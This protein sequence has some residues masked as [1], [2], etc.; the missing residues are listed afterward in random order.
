MRIASRMRDSRA[1]ASSLRASARAN[2]RRW[3]PGIGKPSQIAFTLRSIEEPESGALRQVE[4]GGNLGQRH[5][6]APRAEQFEHIQ[7]LSRGFHEIRVKLAG[8]RG[9]R[10]SRPVSPEAAGKLEMSMDETTR[11]HLL[12]ETTPL[13][14]GDDWAAI[15][16]IWEPYVQTDDVDAQGQLA[17]LYQFYGFDEGPEKD[18]EM[19]AMLRTAA[20]N[21]HADA[22]FCLAI[23][24]PAGEE[25]DEL[26]RKAAAHGNR[27]AQCGLGALYATGDWTGPKDPPL[28]VYWYTRAA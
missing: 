18:R 27:E 4:R 21:G 7:H 10:I 16:R 3:A 1:A 9:E 20:A 22:E 15:E 5:F 14:K 24:S 19:Q 28:A 12:T 6:L 8:H 11:Q 23:F 26:F 25:R 2:L 17:Y 13:L